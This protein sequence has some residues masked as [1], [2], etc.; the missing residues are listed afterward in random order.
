MGNTTLKHPTPTNHE[1]SP[2]PLLDTDHPQ[3]AGSHSTKNRG[4]SN[5]LR[6]SDRN[7]EPDTAPAA[8]NITAKP[9]P[10]YPPTNQPFGSIPLPITEHTQEERIDL[11]LGQGRPLTH[12]GQGSPLTHMFLWI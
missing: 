1:H 7:V 2:L 8:G 10:P 6:N 11:F 5:D 9:L 12:L 4:I 3:T